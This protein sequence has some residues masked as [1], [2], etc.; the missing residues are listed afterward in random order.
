ME[1]CLQDRKTREIEAQKGLPWSKSY[2]MPTG[3][4]R[5]LP[6]MPPASQH[7]HSAGLIFRSKGPAERDLG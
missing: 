3:A 1:C 7:V 2:Y 6:S 5:C 4:D